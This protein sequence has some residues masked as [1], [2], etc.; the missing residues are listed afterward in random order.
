M[1]EAEYS[2]EMLAQ[3][4]GIIPLRRHARPDEIAGLYVW[5]ASDEAA[6]ASGAVFTLDGAESVGSAATTL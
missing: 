3:V 4:N 1:Q 2:A 6:Y 5:L